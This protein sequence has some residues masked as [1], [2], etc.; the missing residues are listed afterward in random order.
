MFGWIRTNAYRHE[1]LYAVGN[2]L[3]DNTGC[4]R[5]QLLRTYPNIEDEIALSQYNNKLKDKVAINIAAAILLRIITNTCDISN[6][7][8]IGQQLHVWQNNGVMA[9]SI[10]PSNIAN[11]EL[12]ENFQ[13]RVWVV[14]SSSLTTPYYHIINPIAKEFIEKVILEIEK[15]LSN[16]TTF[17]EQIEYSKSI[18]KIQRLNNM[19]YQ[20]FK[21]RRSKTD[22][23]A[24][25]PLLVILSII[26]SIVFLLFGA[27]GPGLAF[28]IIGFVIPFFEG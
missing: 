23:S 22:W 5:R 7:S 25:T 16:N 14:W 18:I 13:T 20:D 3:G 28:L 21:V 10:Q 17:D 12:K 15:V 8:S 24:I 6:I 19:K 1:I 4:F 9:S 26:L 27:I 2:L 11:S